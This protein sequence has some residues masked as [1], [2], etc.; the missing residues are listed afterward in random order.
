[1]K[2]AQQ[3]KFS[4]ALLALFASQNTLAASSPDP[5]SSALLTERSIR[6]FSRWLSNTRKI[7][8]DEQ[9][10]PLV[11]RRRRLRPRREE[12]VGDSP[13]DV[14]L[15]LAD[16]DELVA[17]FAGLLD[18]SLIGTFFDLDLCTLVETAIGSG[19][20]VKAS[21]SCRGD[22]EVG[23]ELD[24][25]FE[26]TDCASQDD[27]SCDAV[28]LELFFGGLEHTSKID[29]KACARFADD[30]FEETCFSYN[31]GNSD[32]FRSKATCSATYGGDN[33]GCIII[34]DNSDDTTSTCLSIDCSPL[35]PL[36]WIN[37]C[38]IEPDS[39]IFRRPGLSL[40]SNGASK[41]MRE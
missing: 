22:L 15:G 13:I 36:G 38:E 5:L 27:G 12:S 41:V 37:T 2:S 40:E 7:R 4:I 24:C 20:N 39:E 29:V 1:M 9:Q 16:D 33:C 25:L 21:C 32:E 19:G 11:D 31:S 14:V 30:E 10:Q 23:L 6:D 17:T 18:E 35:L 8:G 28:D 3:Q 26:T 34:K